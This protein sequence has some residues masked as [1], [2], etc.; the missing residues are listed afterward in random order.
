MVPTVTFSVTGSLVTTV[1][2]ICWESWL[3]FVSYTRCAVTV[4]TPF[5]PF[6]VTRLVPEFNSLD[7]VVSV[8]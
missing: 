2:R 6:W 4:R 8:V 7:L 3:P 1:L 5:S